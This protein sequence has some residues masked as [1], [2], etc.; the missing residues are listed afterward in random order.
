MDNHISVNWD[1]IMGIYDRT[2]FFPITLIDTA[3]L[4]DWF[5]HPSVWE[6]LSKQQHS[7]CVLAMVHFTLP[8]GYKGQPAIVF[9]ASFLL[10][11]A[12]Q[13]RTN[14]S[15]TLWYLKCVEEDSVIL[16]STPA[17]STFFPQPQK[18]KYLTLLPISGNPDVDR[19]PLHS[20]AASTLPTASREGHGGEMP[21][22]IKLLPCFGSS[23]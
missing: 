15:D 6:V 3:I 12:H 19:G 17:K 7:W 23:K 16:V 2:P 21:V 9:G 11:P 13:A 14:L 4:D 5:A 1:T 18:S 8:S 10:I 22:R 20:F